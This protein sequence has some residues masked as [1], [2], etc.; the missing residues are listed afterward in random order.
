[1]LPSYRPTLSFIHNVNPEPN[2]IH[3]Q[4]LYVLCEAVSSRSEA[5]LTETDEASQTE[6]TALSNNG[7]LWTC[8]VAQVFDQYCHSKIVMQQHLVNIV[9]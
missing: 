6:R 1:M 8:L 9:A 3:F 2:L 5:S 7:P 4:R